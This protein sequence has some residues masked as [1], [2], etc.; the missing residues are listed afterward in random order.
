[1]SIKRAQNKIAESRKTL[2]VTI[3][4]SALVWLVILLHD[5]SVWIEGVLTL[6]SAIVLMVLNNRCALIPFYSR[7]VS[8][9]FL[10]LFTMVACTVTSLTGTIVGACFAL[11]Y[12]IIFSSYQERQAPGTVYLAF[13]FLGIT[14]I[15]FIQILYFLPILWLVMQTMLMNLGLRAF[16][17]S[18]LGI[19]TP[20]W[21]LLGYKVYTGDLIIYMDHFMDLVRFGLPLDFSSFTLFHYINLGIVTLLG[22]IGIVHFF[23]TSYTDKIRTRMFYECFTTIFL[24]TLAFMIM[25]PHHFPDLFAILVVSASPLFARFFTLSHSRVSN[26]MFLVILSLTIAYTVFNLWIHSTSY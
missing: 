16:F 9:T 22:I 3:F 24:I 6:A 23:L 18:L 14:S 5:T 12:L 26:I 13:I 20:Y 15:Y 21:F 4:Y 1:M 2:P 8:C 25:Q 10:V 11:F 7:S 17:A 19:L